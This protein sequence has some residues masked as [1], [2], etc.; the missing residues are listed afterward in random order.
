MKREKR[1]EVFY[2]AHGAKIDDDEL[3]MMMMKKIDEM[4]NLH[5][6]TKFHK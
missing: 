2:I 6:M 4:T 5:K 3:M 1:Q